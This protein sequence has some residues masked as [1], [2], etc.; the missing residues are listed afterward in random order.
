M[1]ALQKT[2][3][4]GTFIYTPTLGSLSVNEHLAVGVDEEGTIRHVA[5]LSPEGKH[6]DREDIVNEEKRVKAVAA[7]WGWGETEWKWIVGGKE[8]RSWWFP[9]FVGKSYFCEELQSFGI[10]VP[11]S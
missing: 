10:A 9:G 5:D 1:V 7:K 2:I 4:T 11:L 6:H 8:G 3:Y